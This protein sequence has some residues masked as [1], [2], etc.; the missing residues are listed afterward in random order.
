MAY[1]ESWH[2]NAVFVLIF[3]NSDLGS[4]RNNEFGLSFSLIERNCIKYYK[5]VKSFAAF[6]R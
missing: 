4:K 5:N 6:E 1:P 3:Q 2:G